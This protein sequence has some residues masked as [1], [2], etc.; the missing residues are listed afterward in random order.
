MMFWHLKVKKPF[1]PGRYCPSEAGQLLRDS[2][3][4]G[5]AFDM[6]T[7]LLYLAPTF[8]TAIFLGLSHL[9]PGTRQLETTP[10]VWTHRNCSNS[11]FSIVHPVML[12]FFPQKPQKGYS[13]SVPLAPA[14]CLLT[15]T[16][17]CDPAW[18]VVT[19][20]CEHKRV[21][22]LGPLLCLFIWSHPTDHHI[23][24][25][26]T[27]SSDNCTLALA[28]QESLLSWKEQCEVYI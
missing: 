5:A 8:Q 15:K 20:F 3:E 4:L 25:H 27:R 18:Y 14:F 21:C 11:Q 9:R 23:K 17:S 6:H 22:F 28:T 19:P 10:I 7:D 13:L 1:W 12:C 2:E 26:R 24:E 16:F